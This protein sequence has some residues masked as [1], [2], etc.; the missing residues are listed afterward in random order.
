[1]GTPRPKRKVRKSKGR[2]AKQRFHRVIFLLMAVGVLLFIWCLDAIRPVGGVGTISNLQVTPGMT[3]AEIAH[4]LKEKNLIKSE[5]MFVGLAKLKGVEADL[6]A[7]EYTLDANMSLS[8]IINRI[9]VGGVVYNTLTIPE[10][11]TIAQ[12]AERIEAKGLGSKAE[13]LRLVAEGDFDFPYLE[14][15]EPSPKRLEGFLFPDTYLIPKGASEQEIIETMLKRFECVFTPEMV[16]RAKELD[17]TVNQVVTLASIVEREARVAKERPIISSV[18][19]NRLQKGMRLQSC[20]TVQYALGYQKERLL[21]AD[22]E[23]DSPYNTYRHAGLP[24]GPIANPGK[25]SLE[26]ALYPVKSDY[27]YFV[28]QDDHTHVFSRTFAEHT[29]AKEQQR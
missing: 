16:K 4:Q 11:Y 21:Y 1:M 5:L 23:I 12:I 26:A 14:G 8:E 10:G 27:L 3:T 6:K 22:L 20:A 13:F 18:F 25:A 19:H 15:L 7:G 9:T 17:M 2:T 28:A 24:P 29:A